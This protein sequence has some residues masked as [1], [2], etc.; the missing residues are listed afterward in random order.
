[1]EV[2]VALDLGALPEVLRVLHRERVEPEDLAEDDEVVLD[3]LLEVE[4]EELVAREQLLDGLTV[5]VE[6]CG[7]VRLDDVALRRRARGLHQLIVEPGVAGS[8]DLELRQLR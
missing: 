1:G 7:A 8:A 3:G 4:P 5:E 2:V 6:V